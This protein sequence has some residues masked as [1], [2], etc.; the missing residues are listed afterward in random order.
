MTTFTQ[1][2]KNFIYDRLQEKLKSL[3]LHNSKLEGIKKLNVIAKLWRDAGFEQQGMIELPLGKVI[4]YKFYNTKKNGMDVHISRG[5]E[6][7]KDYKEE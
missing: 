1:H 3:H 2:E 6:S 4:S 7:L 5:A